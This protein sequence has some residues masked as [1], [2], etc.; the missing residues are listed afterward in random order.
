[1]MVAH[2]RDFY[3]D[4]LKWVLI[5]LVVYGHA[6]AR[7][8]NIPESGLSQGISNFIYFFHMPLFVFISGRFSHVK[9]RNKYVKGIFKLIELYITFQILHSIY[10]YLAGTIVSLYSFLLIPK[11]SLWYLI[12]LVWWRCLV[13]LLGEKYL[14]NNKILVII[15]SL[16]LCLLSGFIP[17]GKELGFQRIFGYLPFFVLGYYSIDYQILA[18]IK[19]TPFYISSLFL[20][21]AF[22]VIVIFFNMDMPMMNMTWPYGN[23]YGMFDRLFF[24]VLS[25]FFCISVIK[26][27]SHER[28]IFNKIVGGGH[29]VYIFIAF[30]CDISARNNWL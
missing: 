13:L 15:I 23:D 9:E 12:C 6:L 4:S 3:W 8:S 25:S 5:A 18:F 28:L 24:L 19:K 21:T 16:C 27:F 22:A 26:V 30:F 14:E 11:F 2:T 29:F 10:L 1:M 20:I 17:V 7:L